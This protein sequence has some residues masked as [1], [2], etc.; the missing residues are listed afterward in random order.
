MSRYIAHCKDNKY[1]VSQ[2]LMQNLVISE[3]KHMRN[4]F[5]DEILEGANQILV[6]E[7]LIRN[8][9]EQNLLSFS[10]KEDIEAWIQ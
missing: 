9:P 7:H 4:S 2:C 5:I 1:E 8:L 6:S 10:H 3:K